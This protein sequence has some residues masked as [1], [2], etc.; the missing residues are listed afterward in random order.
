MSNE[1][2]LDD[3][4]DPSEQEFRDFLTE[5]VTKV[6]SGEATMEEVV[7]QAATTEFEQTYELTAGFIRFNLACALQHTDATA[8]AGMAP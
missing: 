1:T 8:G 5:C 2:W 6:Q 7:E 4:V 3:H